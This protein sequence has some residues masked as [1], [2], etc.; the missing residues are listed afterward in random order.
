MFETLMLRASKYKS[1][2]N[3]GGGLKKGDIIFGY[4]HR[5]IFMNL[6]YV[7]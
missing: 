3:H 1:E 4:S 2:N 7:M 5:M 6:K